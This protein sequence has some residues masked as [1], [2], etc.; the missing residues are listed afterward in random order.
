MYL[1]LLVFTL[2]TRKKITEFTTITE[3]NLNDDLILSFILDGS[4]PLQLLF[5]P[6]V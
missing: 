4:Q 5:F 2:L 3:K 1:Y 6:E